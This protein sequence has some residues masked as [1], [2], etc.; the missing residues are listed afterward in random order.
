M[1]STIKTIIFVLM[2]TLE[3]AIAY[4]A[5]AKADKTFSFH[6]SEIVKSSIDAETGIGY[7]VLTKGRF[8]YYKRWLTNDANAL[9]AT[10]IDTNKIPD[11]QRNWFSDKYIQGRILW[12]A[13]LVLDKSDNT[14]VI[15][16]FKER[17]YRKEIQRNGD[18]VFII[19]GTT[20]SEFYFAVRQPGAY[21][22]DASIKVR[23][24]MTL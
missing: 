2:M 24:V 5:G 1:S 19:P 21:I 3:S 4:G 23:Y 7:A 12:M 13:K 6:S 9:E 22:D 17:K 11:K 14:T 16:A 15:K 20:Y 10:V 18:I 8:L